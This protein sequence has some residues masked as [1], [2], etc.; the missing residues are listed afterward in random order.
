[1]I[2]YTHIQIIYVYICVCKL[3][4]IYVCVYVVCEIENFIYPVSADAES[5]KADYAYS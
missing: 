3:L 5:N 2:I 1:M 4:Y